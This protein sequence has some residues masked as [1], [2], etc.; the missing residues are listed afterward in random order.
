MEKIFFLSLLFFLTSCNSLKL[1]SKESFETLVDLSESTKIIRAIISQNKLDKLLEEHDPEQLELLLDNFSPAQLAFEVEVLSSTIPLVIIYYFKG[2][3][4]YFIRQ[5]E[6]LAQDYEN[7][8]KFVIIDSEK[9]FS[10][11]QDAEIENFPTIIFSKNR[12]ILE[13]IARNISVDLLKAKIDLL[14]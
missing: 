14:I 5:L 13:K 7:K 1:G 2:Q 4:K 10:L 6:K 8:V 3:E 12:K 11:A 9:L